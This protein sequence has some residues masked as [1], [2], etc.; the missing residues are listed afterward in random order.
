MAL[1]FFVSQPSS[2][3]HAPLVPRVPEARLERFGVHAAL[4]CEIASEKPIRRVRQR[5]VW[6]GADI[7][8]CAR[9]ACYANPCQ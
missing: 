1:R 7:A 8:I 6:H 5:W 4:N 9:G 3:S 2:E